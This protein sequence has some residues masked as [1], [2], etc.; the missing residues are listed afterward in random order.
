MTT[1]AEAMPYIL[2]HVDLGKPG[3]DRKGRILTVVASESILAPRFFAPIDIDTFMSTGVTERQARTDLEV[4]DDLAATAGYRILQVR[5]GRPL[6]VR[7]RGVEIEALLRWRHVPWIGTRDRVLAAVRRRF[8]CATV[9]P[10]DAIAGQTGWESPPYT[11]HG[12]L[13]EADLSVDSPA[14]AP[15]TPAVAPR[16]SSLTSTNA[17][18]PGSGATDTGS[19]SPCLSELLR[20]S[21]PLGEG[22]GAEHGLR[23]DRPDGGVLAARTEKALGRPL[24]GSL[25]ERLDKLEAALDPSDRD[26]LLSYVDTLRGMRQVTVA[27]EAVE[28]WRPASK[29]STV[30]D[31]CS[32]CLIDLADPFAAR[33]TDS[34]CPGIRSE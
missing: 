23:P 8:P 12:H 15:R 20:N 16:G 6:A 31:R 27:V 26:E 22:R 11:R 19:A 2:E 18:D 9:A 25:R 14:A 10:G 29:P 4:L 28:R 7:F 21:S 30:V 3:W 33:C 32:L 24:Y 1:L 34:L 13:S 5:P 17:A